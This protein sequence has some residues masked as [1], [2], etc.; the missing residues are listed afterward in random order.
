L[1]DG[2]GVF[3]SLAAVNSSRLMYTKRIKLKKA[4]ISHDRPYSKQERTSRKSYMLLRQA[5][6]E[7]DGVKVK[8]PNIISGA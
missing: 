5:M 1:V 6:S 4:R 2:P 8:I 3:R 7:V